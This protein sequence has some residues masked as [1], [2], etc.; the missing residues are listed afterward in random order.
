MKVLS[1]TSPQTFS[2]KLSANF[3]ISL[4]P[5]KFIFMYFCRQPSILLLKECFGEILVGKSVCFISHF[6]N[7]MNSNLCYGHCQLLQFK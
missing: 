2:D 5:G 1:L 6:G 7:Q 3:W 4:S